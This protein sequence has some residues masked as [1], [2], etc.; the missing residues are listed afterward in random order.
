MVLFMLGA[1]L[2]A[3]MQASAALTAIIISLASSGLM[4]LQ[5]AMC[6]ILGANVGTCVTSLISSMGT[7]V[8]AKRAAMVHLLFNVSGCIIFIF[9]VAFAGKY[10]AKAL[11]GIDTQWQVAIFHMVFNVLT[12]LALLP[13]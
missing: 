7:N 11:A 4:S 13:F 9:P 12:T 8:N 6:I 2:T 3:A 5:M 1:A 10:I